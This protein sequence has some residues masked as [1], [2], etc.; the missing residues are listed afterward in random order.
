[1]SLG[2]QGPL[3][4][5]RVGPN[6]LTIGVP[7]AA[8]TCVGPVSP[9]TISDAPRASATR[10]AIVV[11]GVSAAAPSDA[12]TTARASASSPGPQ[13]TTDARR[14]RSR[15][16]RATA[17]SRSGG[18]RLLGQAAP[19]LSSAYLP[20]VCAATVRAASE[21]TRIDGK[22][23]R[24]WRDAEPR[25]Q[26]QIDVNDVARAVD[27]ADAA[28]SGIVHLRIEHAREP[29]PDVRAA[30]PTTRG[31]PDSTREQR[32]FDQALQIDRHVVLA[33]RTAPIA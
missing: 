10:S 9:D 30:K 3:R 33:R 19:G 2:D 14:C 7:T 25:Q 31:A 22:L 15:N 28:R 29:L 27:I 23:R 17:P 21:S 11:G 13:S 1:M 26:P 5:G 12:A 18:H 4:C 24:A 8:A 16:A 20:E 32:R 6:R